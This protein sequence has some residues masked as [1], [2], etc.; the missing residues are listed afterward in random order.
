MSMQLRA[1][2]SS[3]KGTSLVSAVQ[4]PGGGGSRS[5][6]LRTHVTSWGCIYIAYCLH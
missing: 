3:M 5:M 6:Q 4:P 2:C 1:M